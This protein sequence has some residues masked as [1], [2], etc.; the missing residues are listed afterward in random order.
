MYCSFGNLMIYI[1]HAL[2]HNHTQHILYCFID[3]YHI[4]YAVLTTQVATFLSC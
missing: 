2:H 3:N 1:L 4:L